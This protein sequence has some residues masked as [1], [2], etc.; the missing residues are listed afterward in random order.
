MQTQQTLSKPV[1]KTATGFEQ[2]LKSLKTDKEKCQQYLRNIPNETLESYFKKNE[3]QAEVLSTI[4]DVVSHDSAKVD[5]WSGNF[6][7]SL[8]K[9]E[10]FEMTLMFAEDSDRK[11]IKEIVDNLKDVDKEL[12]GKVRTLYS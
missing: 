8:A 4:L 2:D 11:S 7:L 12:A 1:P 5:K 9:S 3:V 10:N 6:L